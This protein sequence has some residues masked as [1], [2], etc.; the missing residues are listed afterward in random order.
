PRPA[1]GSCRRAS[2]ARSP[3]PRGRRAA[4]A[5]TPAARTPSHAARPRCRPCSTSPA[6]ARRRA[7]CTTARP[8][9]P[10]RADAP[11]T[12]PPPRPSNRV[13][14]PATTKTEEETVTRSNA[15]RWWLHALIAALALTFAMTAY[16][17]SGRSA[18]S[19]TLVIDNSFTLKTSDPQRGF[20]STASI[21][22]RGIFDTLF[23]YSKNDLAH[24]VPLLV[25]SWKATNSAT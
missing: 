20:D 14:G 13:R 4:A 17:A 24:P 7:G 10:R 12:W 6:A 16:G 1:P 15:R 8:G 21:V 3:T 2:R 11:Q 25:S 23:T 22:D 9:R 18:A 19:G 5:S